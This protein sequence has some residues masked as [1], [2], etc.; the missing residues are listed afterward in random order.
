MALGKHFGE[1]ERIFGFAV[2][3]GAAGDVCSPP[4]QETVAQIPKES[5]EQ[6]LSATDIVDLIQSYVPLKRAGSRFRANCPFHNEKT[7]SFYVNPS[8]Q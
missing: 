2:L 5:I 4:Q 1:A 6:V 3:S 7:P 8:S